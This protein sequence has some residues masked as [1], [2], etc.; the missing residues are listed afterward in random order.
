MIEMLERGFKWRRQPL[1]VMSTNSGSDRQSVCWQEHQH[2]VRVAAG[3]RE[4]DTAFTYVGEAID[5]EAFAF[6]C[7]LD[8][9]D[10]PLEDPS[11]WVKANPLLGVTVQEDYLAGVVRQAKAIP[12]KLNNIL[13]LQERFAAI[14]R[15]MM[16]IMAMRTKA[17]VMR[18]CLS[19]SRARRRLRLIHPMVRSTIQRLGR[20]TKRWLSQRRTTS[21]CHVPVRAT[22]SPSSAPDNLHRRMRAMKGN[23]RR[24]CRSSGSAPSRSCTLA[25]CTTTA[26]SMPMV[27]VSRWRL[28]PTT[29]LPAS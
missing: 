26:S 20:T 9:H 18:Q 1:L 15:S 27:S 4:P 12:G 11:C 19:K 10:D 23:K 21:I 22:A 2:A 24:A 5:D 6:V 13:R 28:R 3:T 25:G 8:P 17:A 16:R 7:A 14:R 29:F